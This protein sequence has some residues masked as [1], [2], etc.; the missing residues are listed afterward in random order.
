MIL[1]LL[2]IVGIS[3]GLGAFSTT[4]SSG[5]GGDN[6]PLNTTRLIPI[7]KNKNCDFQILD[8]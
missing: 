2:G 6:P 5:A 4:S 1:L 7:Q 8:L 3:G